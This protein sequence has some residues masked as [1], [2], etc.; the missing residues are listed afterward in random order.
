MTSF[1]PLLPT[2]KCTSSFTL[3]QILPLP[4]TLSRFFPLCFVSCPLT[5][6]QKLYTINYPFSLLFVQP[7]PLI[8]YFQW[9]LNILKSLQFYKNNFLWLHNPFQ[10]LLHSL[11]LYKQTSWNNCSVS[12]SSFLVPSKHTSV[13][14]S[15]RS[16]CGDQVTLGHQVTK[17]NGCF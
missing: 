4:P 14:L 16:V 17:S 2:I 12:I 1:T 3:A 7:F 8:G 9:H 11:L 6:S 5:P 15:T 13:W 10:L